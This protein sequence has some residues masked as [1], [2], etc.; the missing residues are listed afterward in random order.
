MDHIRVKSGVLLGAVVSGALA[1]GALGGAPTAKADCASF[2]GIGNSAN[3]TSTLFSMA[4]AVGSGAT[5][6]ANGTFTIATAVG[7]Y[8]YSE[9]YGF[10]S[11]ATQFGAGFAFA[12]GLFDVAVSRTHAQES[13]LVYTNVAA[14]GDFGLAMNINSWGTEFHSEDIEVN[15]VGNIAE[16]FGGTNNNLTS[17]GSGG[18]VAFNVSGSGNTVYAGDGPLAIAGTIGRSRQR[19]TQAGP[20]IN[21]NNGIVGVAAAVKNSKRTATPAA[22]ATHT[23]NKS[24]APAASSRGRGARTAASAASVGHKK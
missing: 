4:I 21:I 24:A 9:T 3:C 11:I 19:V 2:F 7:N 5:A 6:Y 23:G 12:S 10:G 18:N 1:A 8:A 13:A 20:G 17:T 22:A 15:G 16:N 14:Q